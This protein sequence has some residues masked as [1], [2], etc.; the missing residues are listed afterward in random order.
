[1]LSPPRMIISVNSRC[2]FAHPGLEVS[3]ALMVA[4]RLRKQISRGLQLR[5]GRLPET[6]E[7]SSTARITALAGMFGPVARSRVRTIAL[8]SGLLAERQ[9]DPEN[10]PVGRPRWIRQICPLELPS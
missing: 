2:D 3:K 10:R 6:P 9:M 4:C 7:S 8:T 5:D 1:V